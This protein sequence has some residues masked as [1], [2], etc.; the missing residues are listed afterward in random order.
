VWSSET[1]VAIFM[2]GPVKLV[3][4][5]VGPETLT[6]RFKVRVNCFR[7]LGFNVGFRLNSCSY[8]TIDGKK[9]RLKN[10]MKKNEIRK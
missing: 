1:A 4:Q 7:G 8:I 3:R 6:T 5:C 9:Y 10:N 2:Q